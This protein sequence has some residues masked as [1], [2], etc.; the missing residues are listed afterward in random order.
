MEMKV[1]AAEANRKFSQLLREVGQG[2]SYVMTSYGRPVARIVP[3]HSR[4]A[5]RTRTRK[6]LLQR[7]RRE[8]VT[9]IGRWKREDLYD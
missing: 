5:A 3:L 6:L 2:S 9:K 7:L 8:A 4:Q 1:S